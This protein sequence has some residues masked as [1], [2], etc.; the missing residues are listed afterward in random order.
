[1]TEK[2]HDY[3]IRPGVVIPRRKRTQ[4]WHDSELDYVRRQGNASLAERQR[5]IDARVKYIP[6]KKD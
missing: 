4:K 1:M 6:R 2:V 5:R 3:T